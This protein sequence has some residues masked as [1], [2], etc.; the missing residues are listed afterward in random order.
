MTKDKK[1]SKDI[2][3][4]EKRRMQKTNIKKYQNFNTIFLPPRV[5]SPT[6]RSSA[7]AAGHDQ[8]P[9]RMPRRRATATGDFTVL[10]V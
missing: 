1:V 10:Y 8:Q 3:T 2:K 9:H 6:N 7:P 5:I 4:N